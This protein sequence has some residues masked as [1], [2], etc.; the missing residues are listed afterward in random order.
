MSNGR[1]LIWFSQKHAL[2]IIK[3]K[4]CFDLIHHD[5]KILTCDRKEI[6]EMELFKKFIN[7]IIDNHNELRIDYQ[8]G[9]LWEHQKLI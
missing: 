7:T 9:K 5:Y 6:K 3:N 1:R 2:K 8:R 4:E